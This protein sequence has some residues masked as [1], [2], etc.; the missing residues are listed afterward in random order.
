MI[1]NLMVHFVSPA[2]N[3]LF[4]AMQHTERFFATWQKKND[5][6]IKEGNVFRNMYL[7]YQ[8]SL[9]TN[10]EYISNDK[11]KIVAALA[12]VCFAS[13]EFFNQS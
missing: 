10:I 7:E 1:D 11:E 3:K 8:K 5:L 13:A 9:K 2:K 4:H 12:F 6:N